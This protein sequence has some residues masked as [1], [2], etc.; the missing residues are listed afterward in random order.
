MD[1]GPP[2]SMKDIIMSHQEAYRGIVHGSSIEIY[3]ALNLP[4]GMEVEIVVKSP[5]VGGEQRKQRL[6]A[7]FGSCQADADD[8]DDF[9]KLNRE[10]RKRNR[11]FSDS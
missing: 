7:L 6:E 1:T 8:L 9:L 4:E 10:Q 5:T 3:P 11:N 2:F